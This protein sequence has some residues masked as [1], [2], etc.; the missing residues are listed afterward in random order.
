MHQKTA[1]CLAVT[2]VNGGDDKAFNS[3]CSTFK[4][5]YNDNADASKT[6][7]GGVLGLRSRKAIEKREA[8]MRAEAAKK[9]MY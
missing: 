4:E 8:I 2:K 9:A 6:W 5:Q 1:T 3:L 7:G